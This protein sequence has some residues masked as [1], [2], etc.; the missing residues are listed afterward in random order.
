MTPLIEAITG[1]PLQVAPD[2]RERFR[3]KTCV[4]KPNV[5]GKHVFGK[6]VFVFETRT[7]LRNEKRTNLTDKSEEKKTNS[8]EKHVTDISN[9]E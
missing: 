3:V 9:Y 2:P 1:R 4:Q 5:F 6:R 8:A 7:F